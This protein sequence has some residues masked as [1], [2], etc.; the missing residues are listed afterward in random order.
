MHA[1]CSNPFSLHTVWPATCTDYCQH[2]HSQWGQKP[3]N[4]HRHFQWEQTP[5]RLFKSFAKLVQVRDGEKES[6]KM[7]TRASTQGYDISNTTVYSNTGPL[8]PNELDTLTCPI[9]KK[10]LKDPMQVIACGHRFCRACVTA[11]TSG[12]WDLYNTSYSLIL[13]ARWKWP[14]FSVLN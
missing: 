11:F 14:M 12:R 2:C 7:A 1:F 13:E 5:P 6:W 3:Q 8:K 9:C 10:V 4:E